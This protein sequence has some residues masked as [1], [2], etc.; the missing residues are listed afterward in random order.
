MS[1]TVLAI[2]LIFLFLFSSLAAAAPATL[3]SGAV[4][5]VVGSQY[6][7]FVKDL[8]KLVNIDSGTGTAEGS[9]QIANIL[10]ER[11]EPLGATVEFRPNSKGT[12]VIARLKGEGK[13]RV[14]LSPH[15]DTVFEPGEAAKRPFRMDDKGFA[16]GP[17][18]GDCKASVTQMVY[19]IKSIKELG[20]KNFG[21]LIVYFDAE[22]ETGSDDEGAI[23]EEL[24]KQVDVAMIVDTARPDWGIA[25][26]RKGS[27]KYDIKVTG[28]S[29]HAGNAPQA[30]AS[31]I[32]ELGNQI[33]MLYKLASPLPKD[34]QNYSADA[35]KAKG[36]SDHGQYIPD[37]SIN[38]GV[39]STTNTKRNRIPDNAMAQIEVRC[40]TMAE[41]QRLDK[42]I[43][44]MATKTV[45]PGVKV[46]IEG[47]IGVN[48]MEKTPRVAKLIDMYKGIAKKEY[49]ADVVEWVAGGITVGN[50]TAKHVPT[51]D[52]LGVESDPMTEHT[53]RESVNLNSFVPR[54]V[55]LILFIDQM[56]QAWPIK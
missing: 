41:L 40:Y 50:D 34:P 46:T 30:S 18:A 33:S 43:K 28:I 21:E 38:V 11:L 36:I 47:G 55:S 10:K 16:Y 8:E 1:K 15:T 13:L 56:S 44:A 35:L 49:G 4:K 48:P 27:A 26:Q 19:M 5:Q 53:D 22:E 17:G 51:I 42:E 24:S 37:N 29:G 31:A 45:V 12:H 6:T 3:D 2:S 20:F 54:T 25:T 14:L 52:A 39:I 23:L 7:D 32:M 9:A